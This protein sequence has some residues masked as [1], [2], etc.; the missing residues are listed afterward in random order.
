MKKL[1]A[2]LAV[3]ALLATALSAQDG[4]WTIGGSSGKL[5]STFNF[6]PDPATYAGGSDGGAVT[7]DYK[8]GGFNTGLKFNKDDFLSSSYVNGSGENFSFNFE[9]GDLKNIWQV[10]GTPTV[11]KLLGQYKWPD[12]LGGITLDAVLKGSDAAYWA[13]DTTAGDAFTKDINSRL[14]LNATLMDGL[15]AGFLLPK[16]F[17]SGNFVDDVLKQM[18]IGAKFASGDFNAALN[19]NLGYSTGDFGLYFGAQYNN[20][21]PGLNAGLSFKGVFSDPAAIAFGVK[22]AYSTTIDTLDAG[23]TVTFV[24]NVAGSTSS[25]S[26]KIE[27]SVGVTLVADTLYLEILR[28]NI[29]ILFDDDITFAYNPRL[30]YNFLGNGLG[31]KGG[32]V[33]TGIWTEYNLGGTFDTIATNK[34]TLGFKW[35]F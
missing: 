10:N 35:S 12:V 34:L 16:I 3:F 4:T 6:V 15:D 18:I 8:N 19:L 14:A 5:T 20:I 28:G 7:V 21:I 32:D 24:Y 2:I 1:I 13:S 9:L 11:N 33:K 17:D 30:T 25:G 31:D 29:T 27:P 22:V 23:I 26:V